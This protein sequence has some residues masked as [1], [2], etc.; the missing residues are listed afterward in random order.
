VQVSSVFYDQKELQIVDFTN[1]T[2]LLTIL[3]IL[4]LVVSGILRYKKLD[5]NGHWSLGVGFAVL[6][7]IHSLFI[8]G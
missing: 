8:V 2:G 3:V 6:F 4:P 1:I 7:M 5:R